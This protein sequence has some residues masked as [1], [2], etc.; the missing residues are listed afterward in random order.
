MQCS[1]GSSIGGGASGGVRTWRGAQGTAAD[2]GRAGGRPPV[3]SASGA[4]PPRDPSRYL[5]PRNLGP[6]N[7]GPAGTRPLLGLWIPAGTHA[8]RWYR[9]AGRGSWSAGPSLVWSL[10]AAAPSRP[11][12]PSTDASVFVRRPSLSLVSRPAATL[13][14]PGRQAR[15]IGHGETVSSS[16]PWRAVEFPDATDAWVRTV[17][18]IGPNHRVPHHSWPRLRPRL[19]TD[20][21]PTSWRSLIS[22]PLLDTGSAV[23]AGPPADR[24]DDPWR[25]GR[26]RQTGADVVVR[27]SCT[28]CGSL[29]VAKGTSG[30]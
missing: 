21:A 18:T 26:W 29:P 1:G 30:S 10:P 28:I 15:C 5:G 11:G 19:T 4:R 13:P 27:S 8:V 25:F 23:C 24:D 9:R 17:R 2:Q 6:W 3:S 20:Q 16:G 14:A 12:E 7:L 22:F